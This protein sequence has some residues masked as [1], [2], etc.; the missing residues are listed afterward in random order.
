LMVLL[1]VGMIGCCCGIS[2][3]TGRRISEW[4][5]LGGGI[6]AYSFLWISA[7]RGEPFYWF[8]AGIEYWLPLA[9]GVILLWLL[10]NFTAWWSKIIVVTMAFM[11]SAIHEVYGAWIVGA[12]ALTWLVRI[13]KGKA[14]SGTAGAAA[15]ASTLGTASIVL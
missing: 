15:L 7:P 6:I 5:V 1:I 4:S 8:P 11:V 3:V 14:G 9:L 13:A 2:V 12:L 10:Y